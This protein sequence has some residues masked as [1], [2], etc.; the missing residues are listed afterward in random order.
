MQNEG[1]FVLLRIFDREEFGKMGCAEI[2]IIATFSHKKVK[3]NL[4]FWY[5]MKKVVERNRKSLQ[6]GRNL[7]DTF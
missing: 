2:A 7:E 5:V 1:S 6:F 4:E 3:K